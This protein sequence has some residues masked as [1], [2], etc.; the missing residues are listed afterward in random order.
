MW[1]AAAPKKGGGRMS[2]RGVLR[3]TIPSEGC[4]LRGHDNPLCS[5]PTRAVGWGVGLTSCAACPSQ[6]LVV[7][8]ATD[9]NRLARELLRSHMSLPSVVRFAACGRQALH[10]A[11]GVGGNVRPRRRKQRLHEEKERHGWRRRSFL[12]ARDEHGEQSSP[13]SSTLSNHAHVEHTTGRTKHEAE[14]KRF[15]WTPRPHG[16]LARVHRVRQPPP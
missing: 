4:I 12:F 9:V 13:T 3:G 2:M 14:K 5:A 10:G 6:G 8:E 16:S 7:G 15:E 1:A 11:D